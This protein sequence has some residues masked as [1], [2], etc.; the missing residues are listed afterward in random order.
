MIT[1]Y[2]FNHLIQQNSIL[3]EDQ[4]FI[5][6]LQKKT[7]LLTGTSEWK[8][9]ACDSVYFYFGRMSEKGTQH[10]ITRIK[11]MYRY[12]KFIYIYH[13][14]ITVKVCTLQTISGFATLA[15]SAHALIPLN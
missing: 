15:A 5:Q 13:L 12:S 3:A 1:L 10:V 9:S 2:H 8:F 11:H 4:W 14:F 6:I 7:S